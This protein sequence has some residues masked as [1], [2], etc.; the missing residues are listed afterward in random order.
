MNKKTNNENIFSIG[1]RVSHIS[2]PLLTEGVVVWIYKNTVINPE[3]KYQVFWS[4][5]KKGIYSKDEL[6]KT[7]I[8]LK[9]LINDK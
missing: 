7:K 5:N 1:T 8:F 2:N 9:E 6:I 4:N 3:K